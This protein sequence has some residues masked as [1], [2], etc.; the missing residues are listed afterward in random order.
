MDK[1]LIALLLYCL[2][3]LHLGANMA[4]P[5]LEGT[6]A[7][8]ALSS[9]NLDVVQEAIH[10][11]VQPDFHTAD[12]DIRYQI[13]NTKAGATIPLLF[14]AMYFE[15]NFEVWL[16]GK[17]IPIQDIPETLQ[18]LR[19][20]DFSVFLPQFDP[21]SKGEQEQSISF[22]LGKYGD[23]TLNPNEM[24]YFEAPLILCIFV[25]KK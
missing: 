20:T 5:Y 15:K 25:S 18:D 9:R 13:H 6:L 1:T 22:D 24:K 19:G 2:L 17:A 11:R 12:F 7:A 4:S 3:P 10:I 21:V 23:Q 14:V 8:S 16:D